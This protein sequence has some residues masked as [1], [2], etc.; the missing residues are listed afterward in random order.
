MEEILGVK[1]D[2]LGRKEILEK[3]ENFLQQDGFHQVATINP[4]FI[5]EAL[6]NQ[7][8]R[9]ILNTC[10]LKIADGMGIQLAFLRKKKSLKCRMAGVDLML[11]ILR[12]A[13]EKSLKIFLAVNKSGL[14]SFKE[15]REAIW[16]AY[17]SLEIGGENIDIFDAEYRLPDDNSQILLCNFGAP[18][19]ENFLKK[20]KN[21]RIRLAMGVGGSFD[22]LTKKVIRAPKFLRQLGLEWFFRFI[23]QPKR[24]LRIWRAVIIFPLKVILN[25]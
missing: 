15:I 18:Y 17:P 5:L 14:S 13:Q 22:Y 24:W 11:E 12:M 10:N 4:E 2:N 9:D 20:Q 8:F 1:I 25:K 21:D 19:Q 7:E 3:V 23:Q 16:R 6:R